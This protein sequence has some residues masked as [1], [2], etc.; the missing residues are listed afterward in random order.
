M[1]VLIA[2]KLADEGV[3]AVRDAGYEADVIIGLSP[4]ELIET[5]PAYDAI[6]VRSATKVTRAVIE[7]GSNLKVIGRAG[8]GI[9]NIDSEAAKERGIVVRNAP[10]ANIVSAAEQ[11]FALMLAC[12]R[13]T[14][15]ANASMHEGKWDRGKFSGVELYEKT[16]A[17][18]GLGKIGSLV[19][20][21]AKAFGMN[22]IAYDPWATPE[23]AA[24][25]GVTLYPEV[26]DLLP[27]ADFITVHLPKTKETLGMFGAAEVAKM[28]DG[29]ILVNAARGGIYQEAALA[30]GLDSGKIYAVG[31]DVYES[32]PPV[33]YPLIPYEQVTLTPHLGATTKEAQLR[34]G[35]QIAEYVVEELDKL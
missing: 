27:L 31:I 32:E 23:H 7:A 6:I 3:A 22:L 18:F 17:I 26:D 28:K 35:T 4:E 9:D 21:R 33:D 29:V 14:A 12:A 16:L 13:K 5:I 25:L 34:A 30:E 15:Q 20:E 8:V 1:K 11:T 24:E 19:A 2:E 10:F